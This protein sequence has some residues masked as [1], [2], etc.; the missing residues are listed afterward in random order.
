MLHV[1]FSMYQ[2]LYTFLRSGGLK[3]LVWLSCTA[4]MLSEIKKFWTFLV[5][6]WLRIS[7][8]LQGTWV[9]SLVWKIPHAVEQL[10]PWATTTEPPCC[11]YWNPAPG[12]WAPQEKPPRREACALQWR[13][14]PAHRDETHFTCSN[15]DPAQTKINKLKKKKKKETKSS[16][17]SSTHWLQRS[18]C[19]CEDVLWRVRKGTV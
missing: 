4:N 1:F 12:A 6:Q 14:A 13:L 9:R 16:L 15:R 10:R 7:L 11:S 17:G 8:P 18:L 19:V 2:V 3:Y 5:V